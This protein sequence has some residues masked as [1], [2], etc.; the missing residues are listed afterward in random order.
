ML[1]RSQAY[2]GDPKGPFNTPGSGIP[3]SFLKK[4]ENT[5]LEE[6]STAPSKGVGDQS[7]SSSKNTKRIASSSKT[8][9]ESKTSYKPVI[10]RSDYELSSDSE[11]DSNSDN[12]PSDNECYEM[13]IINSKFI[14]YSD[15]IKSMKSDELTN[16]LNTI[17]A[18]KKEYY[19]NVSAS[20]DVQVE[21]LKI[22]EFICRSELEKRL[23]EDD[24]SFKGKGKEK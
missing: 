15:T 13:K 16:T 12:S 7:T 11:S 8:E 2:K 10:S 5:E 1:F 22:K 3:S 4:G 6:S 19:K 21:L 20:D 17:D 24:I 18:M 9:E 23:K 14:I